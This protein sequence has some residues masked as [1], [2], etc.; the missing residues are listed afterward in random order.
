MN[1]NLNLEQSYSKLLDE[2]YVKW[3]DEL[4]EKFDHK[5]KTL[6]HTF[7]NLFEAK[8]HIDKNKKRNHA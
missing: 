6:G 8:K 3:Q 5:Y 2:I 1:K 4:I 7:N